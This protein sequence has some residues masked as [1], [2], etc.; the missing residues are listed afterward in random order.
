VFAAL[1]GLARRQRW[2]PVAGYVVLAAVGVIAM[3]SARE[4]VLT[5]IVPVVIGFA[6]WIVVSSALTDKLRRLEQ[7]DVDEEPRESS[8]TR[9]DFLAITGAVVGIAAIA[10][11]AGRVAGGARRRVE[12]ARGLLR[13]DAVTQPVV[14]TGASLGVDGVAPWMT[15]A[16]DFYLIDTA[17]TKPAIVPSE[18]RLRI[19]GMV[20]QEV[21]ISYDD[22]VAREFMEQWVTLNCV[23]NEVG[24]ELVGNAWWSGPL[25][26]PLLE[27]AG[28]QDGADAVLQTSDDG[29]TCG[30]P[31]EA[32]TDDRGAMLA[33]AM[34]G[35]AL[36][37]E[38][39]FPVRTLVPGLYGYV[40][41]TKWVVDLEVTRFADIAAY[42]TQRG[43]GVKGPVKTAS[44]VDVPAEGAQVTAGSVVI[45]GSAWHQLTGIEGV[46]VSVDGGAW[47]SADLGDAP[48]ADTW[49]QW[50]AEVDLEPGQH[51]V[52]VRA[53]DGDG[54]TQTSVVRD[55]LPDGATGW[56]DVR[57]SVA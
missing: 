31:L 20:D 5:D 29:W 46:E 13:L 47:V 36:P 8:R 26:A 51:R 27:Q 45:A 57:F 7:L 39:G 38:H 53:T 10:S 1:G 4:A 23:S 34:N 35:E 3:L 43:W 30:T 52:R 56:D 19:H 37:V 2:Y 6:V 49:V 14:P 21:E 15:P 55:V 18:W 33:V 48:S 28:V 17:F 54:E 12:T 25:L 40:S 11:V 44:R 42:W 41:A 9:R 16:A 50:R 32:L 22:L 24:G